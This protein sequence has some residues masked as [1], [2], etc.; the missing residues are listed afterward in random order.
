M[1]GKGYGVPRNYIE[2][3]KWY[4][5][6]ADQGNADA[7]YELGYMYDLGLGELIQSYIE[8]RKW[9]R[10]AADQGHMGAKKRLQEI[11]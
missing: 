1:Y 9:Y 8:A 3:I 7:Q 10:F 4:K 2:A 6:A 5:K 11:D